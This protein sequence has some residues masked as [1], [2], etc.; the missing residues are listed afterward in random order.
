MHKSEEAIAYF[1]KYFHKTSDCLSLEPVSEDNCTDKVVYGVEAECVDLMWE[2]NVLPLSWYQRQILGGKKKKRYM[3]RI[4]RIRD[5]DVYSVSPRK[6]SKLLTAMDLLLLRK[7]RPSELVEYDGSKSE[8][9]INIR[10]VMSK[11]TGLTNF[12]AYELSTGKNYK[13]FFKL[14]RHL[15]R[16]RNY[17]SFYCIIRAFQMQKL[18]LRKLSVLSEYMEKSLSYF[19]MRQILDDLT[20]QEVFLIC[21]LD[22]YIKD[23]EDSNRNKSNEIASMRFCR[24]VEILIKL[25]GQDVEIPVSHDHE[26][27]LLHKFWCHLRQTPTSARKNVEGK[28]GGQFLLI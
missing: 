4:E 11:N 18:D 2:D 23:V 1:S 9:C 3:N 6:L 16:K 24:L 7:I 27:F 28:Y 26:H 22:I 5:M 10:H 21:P 15:E 14:L 12:V 13:Y 8:G 17:N 25:Q 20:A 19:D